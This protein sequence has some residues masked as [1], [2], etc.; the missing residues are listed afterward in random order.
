MRKKYDK[1]K[2]KRMLRERLREMQKE[3]EMMIKEKWEGEKIK[4]I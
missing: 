1:E 2:E 3:N 4:K